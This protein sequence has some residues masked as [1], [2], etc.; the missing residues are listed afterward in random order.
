[1]AILEKNRCKMCN[2]TQK[3]KTQN[4]IYTALEF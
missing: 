3:C 1:M 4:K 2:F